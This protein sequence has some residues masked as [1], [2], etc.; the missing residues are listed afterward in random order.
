MEIYRARP[1]PSP[2]SPPRR[3]HGTTV[4][5]PPL[6]ELNPRSFC[7]GFVSRNAPMPLTGTGVGVGTCRGVRLTGG[8]RSSLR[9]CGC[10]SFVH[11]GLGLTLWTSQHFQN[12]FKMSP[13]KSFVYKHLRLPEKTFLI[14][15]SPLFIS[16]YETPNICTCP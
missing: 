16:T 6:P 12:S 4:H 8:F 15:L 11:K 3:P 5:S 2:P 7:L 9:G 14:S 10:N 13:P 1:S